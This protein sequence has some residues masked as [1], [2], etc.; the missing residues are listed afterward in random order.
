MLRSETVKRYNVYKPDAETVGTHF[1]D[2]ILD[3]AIDRTH[4]DHQH[5]RI[6]GT[7]SAQQAPGIA[8][9]TP[10]EFRRQFGYQLQGQGL[11]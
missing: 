11:L 4:G 9:K 2:G 10:A 8:S 6:V 5:F 7:I 1:V 3:G